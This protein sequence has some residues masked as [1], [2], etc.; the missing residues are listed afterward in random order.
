MVNRA[1][2]IE[3]PMPALPPARLPLRVYV[4]AVVNG[5]RCFFIALVATSLFFANFW[6]PSAYW[7][8]GFPGL[9]W[10]VEVFIL[11]LAGGLTLAGR[12]SMCSHGLPRLIGVVCLFVLVPAVI[13][14]VVW[15]TGGFLSGWPGGIYVYCRR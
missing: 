7:R 13:E 15:S 9:D 14:I 3:R 2:L 11:P 8:D 5:L 4:E 6:W 1:D 12:L 10:I